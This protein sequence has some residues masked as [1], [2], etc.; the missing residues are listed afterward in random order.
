MFHV[1]EDCVRLH[2]A[3]VLGLLPDAREAVRIQDRV[4][5]GDAAHLYVLKQQGLYLHIQMLG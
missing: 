2:N 4:A 1:V 3:Q 5:A